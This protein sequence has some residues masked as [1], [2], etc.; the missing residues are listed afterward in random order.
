M[1]L[2]RLRPRLAVLCLLAIGLR[3]AASAAQPDL[4][5]TLRVGVWT[6]WHDREVKL[7][8][9]GPG[10]SI[11]FQTCAGCGSITVTQTAAI[12]AAGDALVLTEPRRSIRTDRIIISAPVT[13]GAH[14]ETLTLPWPVAVTARS[15][16]L[17][18][19]VTMPIESY[20]ERV[21]ASESDDADSAASLEAL[22]VVVRTFAV[23]QAHGHT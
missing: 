18:L 6:L 23:H 16:S 2:R 3:A 12:R 21:V 15:G 13:L 4:R 19:A 9:A 7:S 10:H 11:R 22:A 1:K 8:S 20:V 17:V 14:G 5:S